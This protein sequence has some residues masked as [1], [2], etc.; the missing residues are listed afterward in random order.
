MIQLGSTVRCK[1]TGFEGIAIGRT[2]WIYG[3]TRIS[4]Q[5][6]QMQDGKPIDPQTFDE[7]QMEVI[8]VNP[9]AISPDSS[10]TS[11]GPRDI[12]RRRPDPSR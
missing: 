9:P 6:R 1:I 11:G 2:E 12:P 3:C 5:A 4:V 7:Q 8:E 10:A